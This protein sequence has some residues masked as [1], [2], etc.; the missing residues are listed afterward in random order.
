MKAVPGDR[1]IGNDGQAN[2]VDALNL[3]F[4]NISR[5]LGSNAGDG[6]L[7]VVEGAIRIGLEPE[8]DCCQRNSVA[9][10]RGNMANALD[11]GNAIFDRLRGPATRAPPALPR[12]ESRPQILPGYLRSAVG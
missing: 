10:R 2:H 3:R 5:K 11:T 8:C 1:G 9:D 12:T 7:N 6:I 4:V